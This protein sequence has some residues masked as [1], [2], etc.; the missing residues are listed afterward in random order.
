MSSVEKQAGNDLEKMRH[1]HC[2]NPH[3]YEYTVYSI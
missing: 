1:E 2:S 3:Y